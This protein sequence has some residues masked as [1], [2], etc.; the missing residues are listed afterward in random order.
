M[1]VVELFIENLAEI[2]GTTHPM[3][4]KQQKKNCWWM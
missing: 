1:H 2:T 3:E 4:R